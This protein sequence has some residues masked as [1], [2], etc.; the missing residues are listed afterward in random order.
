MPYTI[1]QLKAE[2]DADPKTLGLVALRN[3]GNYLGIRDKLNATY[4]TVGVVYR[5]DVTSAEILASLVWTE[6][7]TLTTNSWLALHALLIPGL[8]DASQLRIRQMFVGLFPS[9]TFPLTNANL[10]A[11]AQRPAP[12]RAEELWGFATRVTEQDVANAVNS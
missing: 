9:A 11:L 2:I 4:G 3:A 7:A 6:I 12:S 8:V 10:T 1:A 5:T